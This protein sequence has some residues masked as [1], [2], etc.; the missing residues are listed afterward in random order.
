MNEHSGESL[1]IYPN[2]ATNGQVTLSGTGKV[3]I[4][5]AIG[6]TVKEM[7]IDG[8]QMIELPAGMYFV[9]VNGSVQKIVVE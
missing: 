6:Q 9:Q 5:N 1:T 8:K 7:E 4:T 3:S 2:P